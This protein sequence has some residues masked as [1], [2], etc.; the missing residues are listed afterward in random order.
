MFG[1]RE[2]ATKEKGFAQST[3]NSWNLGVGYLWDDDVQLLGDGVVANQPLP[4]GESEIQANL[5][6]FGVH[7]VLAGILSGQRRAKSVF[8]SVSPTTDAIQQVPTCHSNY[9]S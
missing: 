2:K 5:R 7:D 1:A 8:P 3:S 6:G 9:L 4:S